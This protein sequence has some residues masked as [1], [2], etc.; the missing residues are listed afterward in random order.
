MA[1]YILDIIL[2]LFFSQ[3]IYN[4]EF[5]LVRF[6][7]GPCIVSNKQYGFIPFVRSLFNLKKTTADKKVKY[8]NGL[9]DDTTKILTVTRR[10]KDCIC[11][12]G[13]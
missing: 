6:R 3:Y 2:A 8:S 1:V 9:V 12:A 4:N 13:V 7:F 5:N 11:H 10:S